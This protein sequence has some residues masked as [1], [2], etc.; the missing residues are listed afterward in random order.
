[1]PN[2]F[3]LSVIDQVGNEFHALVAELAG[4]PHAKRP[5][6]AYWKFIAIH[7]IGEKSLRMRCIGHINAVPPVG[8]DR[9][10]DNV[11]GLREDSNNIQHVRERYSDPLGYIRPALFTRQLS[12]LAARWVSS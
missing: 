11:S 7:P 9:E 5:A 1:M 3:R 4:D 2:F 10:V 6:V 8:L 12:D